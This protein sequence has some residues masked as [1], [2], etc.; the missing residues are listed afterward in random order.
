MECIKH[1]SYGLAKYWTEQTA[2]RF[3]EKFTYVPRGFLN[4]PIDLLNELEHNPQASA[5][6][7]LA[8]MRTAWRRSSASKPISWIVSEEY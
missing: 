1:R 2:A 7:I 6:K 3:G 8:R 4:C 5:P